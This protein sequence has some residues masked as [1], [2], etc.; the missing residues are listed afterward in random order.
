MCL[1]GAYPR[2]TTVDQYNQSLGEIWLGRQDSNLGMAE[3]KSTALPLGYAPMGCNGSRRDRLSILR[4]AFNHRFHEARRKFT[5][6]G[7]EQKK[8]TMA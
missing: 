1:T 6:V 3:S 8:S 5:A 2:Q 4:R 7:L